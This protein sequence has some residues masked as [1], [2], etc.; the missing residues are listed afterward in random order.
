M[1]NNI[2]KEMDKKSVVGSE[3]SEPASGLGNNYEGTVDESSLPDST[4]FKF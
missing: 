2:N 3:W 1:Y 4:A